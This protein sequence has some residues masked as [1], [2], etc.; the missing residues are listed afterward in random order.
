MQGKTSCKLAEMAY[1]HKGIK[2]AS[3]REGTALSTVVDFTAPHQLQLDM[4]VSHMLLVLCCLKS[5]PLNSL[6]PPM[7]KKRGKGEWKEEG[8]GKGE[9]GGQ[10]ETAIEKGR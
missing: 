5:M 1:Q 7:E 2:A 8:R 3:Q 6:K 4:E 10:A 9:R